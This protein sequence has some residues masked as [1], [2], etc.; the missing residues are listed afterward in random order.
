MPVFPEAGTGRIRFLLLWKVS[1]TVRGTN[2]KNQ[3]PD[4]GSDGS[5]LPCA[6]EI[7]WKARDAHREAK[8]NK[9]DSI[10]FRWLN[11]EKYRESQEVHGQKLIVRTWH[12]SRRSTSPTTQ[13]GTSGTGTK[14][15]SYRYPTMT[16]QA[17]PTQNH[18]FLQREQGRQ[19][20]HVPKN[21]RACQRLF[22][23]AFRADLGWHSH[24]C[25]EIT[26][27][28]DQVFS[29]S[30]FNVMSSEFTFGDNFDDFF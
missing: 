19:N 21:E 29:T 24:N 13:S 30:F 16:K 27:G 4:R 23:D 14:T 28:F 20:V 17:G 1:S 15:L 9:H 11:D 3:N 12:T 10:V 25:R 26:R 22:D 2:T 8:K 5:S 7:H 18:A 6:S